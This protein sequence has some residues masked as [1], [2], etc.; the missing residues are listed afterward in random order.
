[1]LLLPFV[2]SFF[3]FGLFR[4]FF[5]GPMMSEEKKCLKFPSNNG[6]GVGLTILVVVSISKI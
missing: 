6:S 2:F 3:H 4:L 1:M 5:E